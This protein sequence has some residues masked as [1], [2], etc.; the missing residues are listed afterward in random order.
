MGVPEELQPIVDRIRRENAVA[1][2]RLAELHE[3][4]YH[5]AVSLAGEMGRQ[6][7]S[8]KKVILFGSALPGRVFRADS[9]I[10][11]AVVGGDLPLLERIVES[12]RAA[13]TSGGALKVDILDLGDARPGIRERILEEGVVLY[14]AG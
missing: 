6:D 1:R 7:S 12:A 4:A 13:D 10:D 9:D 5:T 14:D 3:G 8:L 2:V 11:L